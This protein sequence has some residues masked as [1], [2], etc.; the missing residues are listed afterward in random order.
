MSKTHTPVDDLTYEQAFAELE[1]IVGA[2]ET[3]EHTLDEAITQYERG[4]SLAKH[5]AS[6]LERN[7]RRACWIHQVQ[8]SRLTV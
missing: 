2:L 8:V 4:Q 5:C 7:L 3:G 1:K 6:L